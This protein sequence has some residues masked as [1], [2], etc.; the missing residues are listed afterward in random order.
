MRRRTS[1]KVG[2]C[3]C[4]SFFASF[5]S[6]DLKGRG[7]ALRLLSKPCLAVD[8][9]SAINIGNLNTVVECDVVANPCDPRNEPDLAEGADRDAGQVDRC[10]HL[11]TTAEHLFGADL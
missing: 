4:T 10:G 6:L 1:C 2:Q 11:L 7:I 3:F 5:G 8:D 9:L